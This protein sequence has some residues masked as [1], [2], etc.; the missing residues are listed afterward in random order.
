MSV[1]RRRENPLLHNLLHLV[2]KQPD[3]RSC[4]QRLSNACMAGDISCKEG[5]RVLS[6]KL[7]AVVRKYTSTLRPLEN[8]K[9]EFRFGIDVA[10]L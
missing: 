1:V 9:L 6:P 10:L 5:G 3:V 2:R 8:L 4:I 7:L